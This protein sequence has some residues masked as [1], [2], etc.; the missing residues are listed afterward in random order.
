MGRFLKALVMTLLI[1]EITTIV[2]LTAV[3]TALSELH[4]SQ[5]VI[6]TGQ[7]LTAIVLVILTAIVYRRALSA[8]N[9]LVS[10]QDQVVEA[11]D[12]VPDAHYGLAGANAIGPGTEKVGLGGPNLVGGQPLAQRIK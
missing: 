5:T 4:A 2:A 9:R 11:D 8:E 1:M 12:P 7:G 6:L 3:W 10:T